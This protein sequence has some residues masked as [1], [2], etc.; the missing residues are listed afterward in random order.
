MTAGRD[1]I[2]VWI[3]SLGDKNWSF[4]KDNWLAFIAAQGPNT[5]T[6]LR[7]VNLNAF[8]WW[9]VIKKPCCPDFEK[10][11]HQFFLVI[12]VKVIWLEC[13]PYPVLSSGMERQLVR[14][15]CCKEHTIFDQTSIK[16]MQQFITEYDIF[17]EC[18]K[19]GKICQWVLRDR[20][21]TSLS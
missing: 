5:S 11:L 21:A 13:L 7:Q 1:I 3:K 6:F 10:Q 15:F 16:M 17:N 9:K 4:L 12:T 19:K 8:F 2:I 20:W 14:C 18:W